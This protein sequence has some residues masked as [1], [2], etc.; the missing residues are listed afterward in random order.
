MDSRGFADLNELTVRLGSISA[1]RSRAPPQART[2]DVG[3]SSSLLLRLFQSDY[4]DCHL[5]VA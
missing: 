1:V 3:G 4:F 5:A 2:M